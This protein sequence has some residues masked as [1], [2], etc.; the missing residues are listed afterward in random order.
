MLDLIY[1]LD[2]VHVVLVDLVQVANLLFC[3]STC[4]AL[5]VWPARSHHTVSTQSAP[6]GFNSRNE[7]RVRIRRLTKFCTILVRHSI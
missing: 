7:Y 3:T 6:A 5:C 4:T 1:V 2:P